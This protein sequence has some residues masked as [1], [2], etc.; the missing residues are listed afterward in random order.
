MLNRDED[1]LKAAEDWQK[2]GHGVA[3]ATVVETWGSA[4]RPVG[5]NLVID[6]D[7]NFLGSVSGGCVEGAVVTEALD[8]IEKANEIID[9]YNAQGLTLTL[10][11]LYYQFVSKN[12]LA[13]TDALMRY[14]YKSS[15]TSITAPGVKLADLPGGLATR[16]R[17]RPD[18]PAGDRLPDLRRGQ[19]LVLAVIPLGE[20]G[21][22]HGACAKVG[23]LAGLPRPLSRTDARARSSPARCGGLRQDHRPNA[24]CVGGRTSKRGGSR[25]S[26]HRRRG[27]GWPS[28]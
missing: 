11:Q 4:P 16:R 15:E 24:R 7:G 25:R 26:R 6:Q 18:R 21:V 10:R 9:D 3:L 22:D 2:A 5:A 20:I 8:V 17:V 14:P 1:I 28:R 12:L 27:L 13:N 23:Q 19:P